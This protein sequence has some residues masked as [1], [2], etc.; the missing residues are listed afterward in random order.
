MKRLH[1]IDLLQYIRPPYPP[2]HFN[3][4]HIYNIW[5]TTKLL[6]SFGFSS[7]TLSKQNKMKQKI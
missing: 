7:R 1:N 6:P 3:D 5:L 2:Y 4:L